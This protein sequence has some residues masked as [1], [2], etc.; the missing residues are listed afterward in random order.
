MTVD[1]KEQYFDP[2]ERY[3]GYGHLA[4]QHTFVQGLRQVDGGTDFGNTP[5][6]NYAANK[7]ARV[8]NLTMD[9]HGE[10][11]GKIDLTYMGAPALGWRQT[12]LRGDDESLRRQL[13]ESLEEMLPKS[14]EVKVAD[15]ENLAD[16]EKP[17]VVH[18]NVKGVPGTP[19]GKRLMVP[20]DLFLTG[21]RATFPTEKRELAV[22]FHYPHMVQDALRVNLPAA[23]TIEAVPDPA[24][25]DIPKTATYNMTVTSAPNNFTTRR[26]YVIGDIIVPQKEYGTLRQFYSQFESKDKENVVLKQAAPES[27]SVSAPETK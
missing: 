9:A 16:Y 5:G 13:R 10:V 11:S 27:A 2:G 26:T 14:L 22:Y 3:C 20:A 19:T 21:E 24:K 8:A 25:A 15:I 12:A 17:L 6:D 18:Y 7:T 23:M 4:W 1:G